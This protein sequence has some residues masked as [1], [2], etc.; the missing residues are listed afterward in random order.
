M[1]TTKLRNTKSASRP[2]NYTEKQAEEK[3]SLN[4]DTCPYFLTYQSDNS[5]Q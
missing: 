3:S 4:F 5:P 2:I 1:A